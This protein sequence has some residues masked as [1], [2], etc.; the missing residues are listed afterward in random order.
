MR[1]RTWSGCVGV[2]TMRGVKPTGQ[3]SSAGLRRSWTWIAAARSSPRGGPVEVEE[4]GAGTI[5]LEVHDH[6]DHGATGRVVADPGEEMVVVDSL[7]QWR[8]IEHE[9][10]LVAADLIE[11]GDERR[12]APG[13]VEIAVPQLVFLRV[14]IFLASRSVGRGFEEL[15]RRSVDPPGADRERGESQPD[16]EHR[17]A[18]LLERGVEDVRGVRPEGGAEEI[19]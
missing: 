1:R 8:P 10:R 11:P 19:G 14:E 4:A 7:H 9:A 5:R 12:E 17:P 13:G 18:P 15:H 16:L 2:Q 3:R 6:E